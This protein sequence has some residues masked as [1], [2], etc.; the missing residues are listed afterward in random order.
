MDPECTLTVRSSADFIA[1]TPYLLSFHPDDSIVVIGTV[2]SRV[3]F[4]ARHDLLAPDHAGVTSIARLV[5]AQ[6]LQEAA[7]LGYG[8]PEAVIRTLEVLGDE[9]VRHGVPVRDQLRITDGRWW[10][11]GCTSPTCC[12]PEGK[13]VPGPDS[14]VAASAIFQGQVALPNRAALIAQV[15]PAEGEER[16]RMADLTVD[17]CTRFMAAGWSGP[18]L[19]KAGRRLVRRAERR[20]AA[21]RALTPEEIA[22]LGVALAHPAVTGHTLDNSR[23]EPWR[24]A[25][26][27]DVTRRVDPFWVPGPACLLA[28]VAWR[29][30]MGALARVAIDRALVQ[31]PDHRLSRTFDRLLAAGIS[32]DAV[33]NLKPPRAR[34]SRR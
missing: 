31:D 25:L 23:D 34:S 14:A 28:Y 32:H 1:V 3:T 30:G 9:L 24:I 21:G 11:L 2:G 27:T 6:R 5:A 18:A 33:A 26:W 10:G 12:P 16:E 15:A 19:E 20:Y 29:A 22:E 13:P 17:V 7:V 4:A 8:R